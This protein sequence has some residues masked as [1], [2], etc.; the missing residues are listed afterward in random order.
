MAKDL[1]YST[2]L[3][4]RR[5][6]AIT[7]EVGNAGIVRVYSGVKPANVAAAITGT[8]LSEHTCGSPFAPAASGGILTPT[9]PTADT[10][11]NNS[12]TATHYRLFKSDG[13]T[14]VMDGTVGTSD[15]DMLM[16]NTVVAAGGVVTPVSWTITSAN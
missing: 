10:S 13:T 16:A 7:T 14:A 9:T 12:G 3:K 15:A 1:K 5:L 8:I 2:A 11:A 4:N 6:D